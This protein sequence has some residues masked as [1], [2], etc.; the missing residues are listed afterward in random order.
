M[1]KRLLD[2][3]RGGGGDDDTA[4]VAARETYKGFEVRAMPR[5]EGNTWR[6]A[7]EIARGEG[8]QAQTRSFVRADTYP[9]HDDAVAVSLRKGQQ[10]ID[11]Q[12]DQL[13]G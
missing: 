7:G 1:F 5:K 12:G 13:F 4:K 11:E 9:A 6:V 3:L 8:E 2:S 10:I